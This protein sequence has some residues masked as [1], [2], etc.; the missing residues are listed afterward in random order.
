MPKP[1]HPVTLTREQA[2]P[3]IRAGKLKP[4]LLYEDGKRCVVQ[5]SKSYK[6]I[7]VWVETKRNPR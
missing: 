7:Y 1:K 2:E 6:R 3:L 5:L 4:A